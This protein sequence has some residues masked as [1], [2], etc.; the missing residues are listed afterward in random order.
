MKNK[1]KISG[2][3]KEEHKA[4]QRNPNK[5]L[6]RTNRLLKKNKG[7]ISREQVKSKEE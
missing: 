7:K 4:H 5:N 6:E 1:G 2:E 3:V